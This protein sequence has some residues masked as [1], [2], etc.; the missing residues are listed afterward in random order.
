MKHRM[1]LVLGLLTLDS[2]ASAPAWTDPKDAVNMV[3]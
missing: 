1:R 2:G 3:S